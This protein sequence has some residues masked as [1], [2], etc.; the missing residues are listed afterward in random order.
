MKTIRM[1]SASSQGNN[2]SAAKGSSSN[3][4]TQ[5]EFNS[6][7]DAGTWN[8]GYVEGMGYVSKEVEVNGSSSSSSDSDSDSWSDPW[9]SISDPWGNS[10]DDSSSLPSQG[11]G[12]GNNNGGSQGG[13]NSSGSGS[14]GS[15]T[16]V[17]TSGNTLVIGTHI[18][19]SEYSRN[20]LR[21]LKG[22]YGKIIIT[23]TF[24]SPE[25]QAKA[26]LNNIK[27]TGIDAQLNLY[28]N[29]GDAVIRAYNPNYSDADN[30]SAMIAEIYNQGPRNVSKHCMTAEEYKTLNIMDISRNQIKN[31]SG[32]VAELKNTFPNITYFDESYNGCIHIEIPQP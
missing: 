31:P 30:L 14:L 11:S 4:Y 6:M 27:K 22:D 29:P 3:P 21:N 1:Y 23:S 25:Q 15:N 5:E 20:L 8:G 26:M 2:G 9:G 28:A 32:F 7:L 16:S 17:S 10:G 24:R 12:G 13:G 18:E 19:I